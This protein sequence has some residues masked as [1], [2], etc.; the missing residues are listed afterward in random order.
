VGKSIYGPAPGYLTGGPNPSYNWDGCCPGGCGSSANNAVCL[1]E[2][3]SPPRD[4]PKQKSYKDFNTSWPLNSWEITENSCGYQVNY[5]RLLSKFVNINLDCHGDSAGTAS[6]DVCGIC[7]G[8][9]TGR[10]AETDPCRCSVYKRTA[11]LNPSA[12]VQYT[13]PSG[14]FVWTSSGSYKDTIPSKSGCD[15]IITTNLT[16]YPSYQPAVVFSGD[17]LKSV[18]LYKTYQWYNTSGIIPGATQSEFTINKSDIYHLVIMDDN[19]CTNTSGV[20]SAVYSEIMTRKSGEF[21]YSII[22]NPNPGQFTFRIDSNPGKEFTLKLV[23][24]FGQVI[25]MRA[26]KSVGINHTEQFDMSCL[27]K[28]MYYLNISSERYQAGEKIVVQ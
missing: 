26:V 23:N 7:S 28:G 1:S 6:L 24:T 16:I 11:F 8:G 10:T 12:C 2:S 17:T 15:S 4:Q 21:R 18:N 13:S 5:I 3:I 14:K 27:S 25:E 20:V 22:P 19:G 9:N